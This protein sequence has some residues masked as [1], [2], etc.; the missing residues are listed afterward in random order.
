VVRRKALWAVLDQ[1]FGPLVALLSTPLL[2]K[3]LSQEDFAVW[4]LS[5]TLIGLGQLLSAGLPPVC[6]RDIATDIVEYNSVNVGLIVGSALLVVG[7]VAALIVIS[8]F[9]IT[10]YVAETFFR[11]VGEARVVSTAL[12]LALIIAVMQELEAIVVGGL[13]ADEQYEVSARVEIA[14]RTVLYAVILLAAIDSKSAIYT[15]I[16]Y[17]IAAAAKLLIKVAVLKRHFFKKTGIR[18]KLSFSVTRMRALLTLSKWQW[19]QGVS[20]VIYTSA[21]KILVA[22]YLNNAQFTIYA[23]AL[24]LTQQTHAVVAG[25]SQILIPRIAKQISTDRRAVLRTVNIATLAA[26][27]LPFPLHLLLFTH[28]DWLVDAWTQTN[29]SPET[30]LVIKILTINFAVLCL[31]VPSYFALIALGE[32]RTSSAI[33]WFATIAQLL[34]AIL[35]IKQGIVVYSVSR[36]VYAFSTLAFYYAARRA[37]LRYRNSYSKKNTND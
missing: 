35:T 22:S 25:A 28:G 2:L 5:L 6:T 29:Q 10:E 23:I 17:A 32:T 26:L 31:N 20:G 12:K 15:L 1:G 14:S 36:L 7:L 24:T 13:K 8:T 21:D 19:I 37:I 30:F 3:V 16:V 4:V 33:S 9:P 18:L 34:I 11:Q 27:L